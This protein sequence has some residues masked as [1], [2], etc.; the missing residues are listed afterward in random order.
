MQHRAPGSAPEMQGLGPQHVTVLIDGVPVTGRI[1]GRIDMAQMLLSNV[2]RVE[3]VFL[4]LACAGR[5]HQSDHTFRPAVARRPLGGVA[6]LRRERG[7]LGQQPGPSLPA[8]FVLGRAAT[9]TPCLRRLPRGDDV[10]RAADWPERR[11]RFLLPAV[12]WE[13][14]QSRL[15]YSA[16]FFD[17]TL[18]ER[19]EPDAEVFA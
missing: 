11:Q 1:D 12:G 4:R 6:Q 18:T 5:R 13:G 2:A 16:Q 14:R 9:R 8:R 17:E 7:E 15:T 3:I 19:G 10:T